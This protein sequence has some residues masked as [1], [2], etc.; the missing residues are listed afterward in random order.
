MKKWLAVFSFGIVVGFLLGRH[1]YNKPSEPIA[2]LEEVTPAAPVAEPVPEAP[3]PVAA[4]APTPPPPTPPP[5]APAPT[6]AQDPRKQIPPMG[7]GEVGGQPNPSH[8]SVQLT[9]DEGLANRLEGD[10]DDLPNQIHVMREERGYRVMYLKEGSLVSEMG[11]HRG[12]L[13]TRESLDSLGGQGSPLAGRVA[14]IL[15][16]VSVY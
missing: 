1:H 11:L 12:D 8:E 15:G 6:P 2:Q 13:I 7:P 5:P 3:Q 14:R 16:H 9:I 10:W 4:T